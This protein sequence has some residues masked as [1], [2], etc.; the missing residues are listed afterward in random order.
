[1]KTTFLHSTLSLNF[2]H[3]ST[4]NSHKDGV[5]NSW[6]SLKQTAHI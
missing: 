3:L 4:A 2:V 1:M 5:T 6:S